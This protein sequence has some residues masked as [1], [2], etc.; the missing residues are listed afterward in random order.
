[1][2]PPDAGP[3]E[4]LKV[5]YL[6]EH[7]MDLRELAD[8]LGAEQLEIEARRSSAR[9]CTITAMTFTRERLVQCV[10]LLFPRAEFKILIS[11]SSLV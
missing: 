3:V 2:L 6:L 8:K 10:S 1:M 4:R 9:S 5:A 11:Q 7:R